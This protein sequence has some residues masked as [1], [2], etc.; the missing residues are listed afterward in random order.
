MEPHH[1]IPLQYSDEFENSLDVV[2]NIIS[3]CSG[4][5]NKF[6]YGE[7]AR[8]L[9]EKLRNERKDEIEKAG[10]DRTKSG[11]VLTL[12]KLWGYYEFKMLLGE[13]SLCHINGNYQ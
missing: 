11:T 1:L 9:I 8:E 3:L 13:K 2:A 7:G 12:D 4:C 6:H 10:I 5:H